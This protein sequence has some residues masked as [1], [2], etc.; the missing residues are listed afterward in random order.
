MTQPQ[1]SYLR[2]PHVHENLVTFA[3]A[4]DVWLAEIPADGAASRAW[5]VTDDQVPVQRPRISP[6]GARI[7]WTG[8]RDGAEAYAVPLDGGPT[9]RLT[10][11]GHPRTTFRG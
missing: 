6:D 9:T 7:G 2:Y 11:W 4:D 5:R 3:A 1:R 10:Y 8:T